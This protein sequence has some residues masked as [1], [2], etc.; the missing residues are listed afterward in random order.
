MR[1]IANNQLRGEYG[2]VVAGQE[3][4]C[5]EDVGR[6][7]LARGSARTPE[8]PNIL[9]DTKVVMPVAPMVSAR[10]PFRDVPV[11]DAEPAG[12]A[13]Q[14]DRVLSQPDVSESGSAD[15]SGRRKRSGSGSR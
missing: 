10:Q 9:Y 11:S 4:E 12:V 3:F 6:E 7:L 15:Y 5:S 13:A 8:P 14:S 2:V 1:L